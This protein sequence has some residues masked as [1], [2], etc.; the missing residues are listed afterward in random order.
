MIV[1]TLTHT[2]PKKPS[3]GCR[4]NTPA[5]TR[6]VLGSMDDPHAPP[7]GTK[8]TVAYVDDMGLIGMNWDNGSSLSLMPSLDSF[9]KEPELKREKKRSKGLER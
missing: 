3:N 2:P 7:P 9:P 1:S 5:G 4:R 6:I 8:G